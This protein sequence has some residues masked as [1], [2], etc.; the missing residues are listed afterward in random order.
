MSCQNSPRHGSPIRCLCYDHFRFRLLFIITALY[1]LVCFFSFLI[2][3]L[4][5]TTV[6]QKEY[7]FSEYSCGLVV[8]NPVIHF[9]QVGVLIEE[10]F[11]MLA[12]D[13]L[14]KRVNNN[15]RESIASEKLIQVQLNAKRKSPATEHS[16]NGRPTS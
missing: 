5:C 10:P 15:I 2:I 9:L 12:L 11:P 6:H 1:Y 8:S 3:C 16:P 13:E 14:C 7:K 4:T